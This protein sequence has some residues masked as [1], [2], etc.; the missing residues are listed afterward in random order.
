MGLLGPAQHLCPWTDFVQCFPAEHARE[1]GKRSLV[2]AAVLEAEEV[3]GALTS[4]C[5]VKL[6]A[7]PGE[8][9]QARTLICLCFFKSVSRLQ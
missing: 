8:Q 1:G 9:I 2:A 4:G 5:G 6:S 7:L 3:L